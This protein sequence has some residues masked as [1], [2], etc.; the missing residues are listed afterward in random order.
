MDPLTGR[1]AEVRRI[2]P[3]AADKSY[4]CPGCN[5]QIAPGVGHVVIVPLGDASDRRHWHTAC[6]EHRS[7]RR[8]GR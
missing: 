8:P 4:R 5:Q 3:F 1:S 2:Q 6:W 7:T